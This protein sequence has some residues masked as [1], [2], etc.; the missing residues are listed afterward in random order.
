V[1]HLEASSSLDRRRN[2]RQLIAI[3]VE[4]GQPRKIRNPVRKASELVVVEPERLEIEH[5][6]DRLR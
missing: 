3:H 6:A 1:K 5:P 4:L 2:V